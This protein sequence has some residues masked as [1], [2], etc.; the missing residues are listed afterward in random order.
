MGNTREFYWHSPRL[1]ERVLSV[2][3]RLFLTLSRRYMYSAVNVMGGKERQLYLATANILATYRMKLYFGG[4]L[5]SINGVLCWVKIACALGIC[6]PT[7]RHTASIR[8]GVT[9]DNQ[10]LH[11]I[12][13]ALALTKGENAMI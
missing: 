3:E 2:M 10:N 8:C 7:R 5:T 1:R 11:G 13:T 12:G 4:D 9:M 6:R